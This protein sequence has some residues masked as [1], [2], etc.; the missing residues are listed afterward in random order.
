[1]TSPL[2]RDTER[3]QPEGRPTRS[4]A[5]YERALAVMPGGVSRNTILRRPH[6]LYAERGEG[7]YVTDIEGVQRIDFANNMASLIHGHA[8]PVVVDAVSTQLRR[9]TAFTL[10]TEVEV[11]FAEHM[12][13]RSPG[14]DKIRFV[15]SGTE[16]VM[17]CLKAAR[18]VT[19]RPKIAKVEGA[20]H[21]GYDYAEVSQA[22]GPQTWGDYDRP[23]SVRT[24]QGTPQTVLEDVVVI[25]FNEPTIAREIL[26]SHGEDI[27]C[28][29]VDFLPHRVGLTPA[30]AGFVEALGDWA[31]GHSAL[32]VADEVITYRS[33][34]GGA[35]EWYDVKPDLTAL[36]KMIG[37]GLPVGAIAG[38]AEVMDVMNPLTPEVLF[39]HSG[40]FS[41]NPL[42][43]AAGL[44][45]M[46]LFDRTAVENLNALGEETRARI[47][48]AIASTGAEAC[49]TG[50]GS[51]FRV[52]TKPFP[53]RNYRDSYLEPAERHR[54]DILI[55]H[56]F[57]HGVIMINTGSL[58]LSTP[59]GRSEIDTLVTA[60]TEAFTKITPV[61]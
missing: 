33:R 26:D 43:M 28:V 61:S 14:F 17:A 48:E 31:H 35:Q 55:D 2:T 9:G 30:T 56:L 37:G 24:V 54:L 7:C 19:G 40:T 11:E 6:P 52:H 3:E 59:M 42:T 8:H 60:L 16:A 53:P 34:Y 21:G 23:A 12:C 4:E 57:D 1:M 38:R 50:A 47:E 22:S 49:V 15:N 36:G 13:A 18:A 27:A 46:K 5:L 58:T 51:M 32:L 44:A 10:G 45:T 20:Y 41:A 29:L 39:P 25:P